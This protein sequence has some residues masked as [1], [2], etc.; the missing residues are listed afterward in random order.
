MLGT[1]YFLGWSF[2]LA[3]VP[4]LSDK[5]GR[6]WFFVVGLLADVILYTIIMLCTNLDVMIVTITLWGCMES[7]TQTIGWIYLMELSP[8]K[9]QVILGSI[10]LTFDSTVYLI[11]AIYFKY[12]SKKWFYYS[13]AGYVF[14]VISCLLVWF[15]PESPTQLIELNRLDEAEAALLRV[16]WVGGNVHKFNPEKLL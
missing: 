2:T 14:L 12:I 6:K 8:K 3:W 9:K 1:G 10:Y 15:L 4:R 11:A 7:C 16:A 5:Y 13:L